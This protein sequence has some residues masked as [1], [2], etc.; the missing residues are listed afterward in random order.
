L[1]AA[2]HAKQGDFR[3]KTGH[4]SHKAGAK[5]RKEAERTEGSLNTTCWSEM[6]KKSLPDPTP[7][8]TTC[9]ESSGVRPPLIK[10]PYPQNTG[11]RTRENEQSLHKGAARTKHAKKAAS[12]S[13]VDETQHGIKQSQKNTKRLN[14]DKRTENGEWCDWE[15]GP[16][17]TISIFNKAA[18][19]ANS[20]KSK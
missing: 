4:S 6:R 14:R 9:A 3:V 11:K 16:P 15:S 10:K 1:T 7:I 13:I 20:G 2:K 8:N 19:A 17:N 5:P 18:P 12:D